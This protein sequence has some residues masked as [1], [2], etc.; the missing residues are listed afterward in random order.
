MQTTQ[1]EV[2][3]IVHID[4][5]NNGG[6]W[7]DIPAA[8]DVYIPNPDFSVVCHPNRIYSSDTLKNFLDH[9]HVVYIGIAQF[10]T[11]DGQLVYNIGHAVLVYGY[12]SINGELR[13]LVRDPHPQGGFTD[14]GTPI[15]NPTSYMRLYENL[16]FSHQLSE[17]EFPDGTYIWSGV[18][19]CSTSYANATERT[20]YPELEQYYANE[21]LRE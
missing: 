20:L 12:V 10:D 2:A 1:Q 4:D 17:D 7:L 16:C 5:P 14:V 15:G 6:N 21:Q 3:E 13:F 18:L 9:G 19:A 8:I 11:E